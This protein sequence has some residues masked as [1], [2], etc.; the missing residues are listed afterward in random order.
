M[1]DVFDIAWVLSGIIGLA[2]G[3]VCRR[4]V[5]PWSGTEIRRDLVLLTLIGFLLIPVISIRDDVGYFNYYFA[6]EQGQD[7]T[8]WVSGARREKHLLSFLLLQ[9]MTFL[10]VAI[11]HTSSRR[12]LVGI[13]SADPPPLFVSR[14]VG[15]T[16]LRAPP[17]VF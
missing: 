1:L 14:V 17:F 3:F 11:E 8:F 6:R 10:V 15:S 4:R 9:G 13:I 7:G 12:K 2:A 16:H 5:G